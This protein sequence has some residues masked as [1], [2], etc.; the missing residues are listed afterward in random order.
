VA[1]ILDLTTDHDFFLNLTEPFYEEH[2][3]EL[4]G[5]RGNTIAM[6]VL[7]ILRRDLTVAAVTELLTRAGL[8]PG[9]A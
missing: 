9:E 6:H 5:S 3:P 7:I 1:D 4:P 2:G 8:V